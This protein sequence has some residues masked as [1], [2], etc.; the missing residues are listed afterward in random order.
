MNAKTSMVNNTHSRPGVW[1]LLRLWGLIGLQSF[2]GGAS[3]L[4]LIRREFVDKRGWLD[5]DE[6]GRYWNLS[7]LTPGI[8]LIALTI[9]IGRKLGGTTGILVSLVGLLL[10]SAMIT[11]LLTAGFKV[12]ETL[13]IIQVILRGIVP[14]T[15]GIMLAVALQF[16]RPLLKLAW[17]EGKFITGISLA[18]IIFSALVII[19]F[20]VSVVLV[21]I[22][23]A[24]LGTGLF[25]AKSEPIASQEDQEEK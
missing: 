16:G 2:G 25:R 8:N 18:I 12:V 13:P 24:M 14:A 23:A 5:K 7:N 17:E 10:P 6:F 19:F 11:C 1:P 3:T 15:G 9:L 21:L 22:G 20:K 4:F